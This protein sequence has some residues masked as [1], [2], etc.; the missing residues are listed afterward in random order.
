MDITQD[1][2][3]WNNCETGSYDSGWVDPLKHAEERR[4]RLGLKREDYLWGELNDPM[5]HPKGVNPI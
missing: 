4:Q 2:L 5:A 3:P 1:R